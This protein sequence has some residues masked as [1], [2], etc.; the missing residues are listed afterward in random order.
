[1]K[2][3]ILFIAF[4]FCSNQFLVSMAPSSS[5]FS[6]QAAEPSATSNEFLLAQLQTLNKPELNMSCCCCFLSKN[7][8]VRAV[9]KK[10]E[11]AVV[12]SSLDY[13]Q[14]QQLKKFIQEHQ[15]CSGQCCGCNKR[16]WRESAL[17]C[18][19]ILTML[20]GALS[21][22]NLLTPYNSCDNY[23]DEQKELC[24]QDNAEQRCFQNLSFAGAATGICLTCAGVCARRE[25]NPTL[26]KVL[27]LSEGPV[28]TSVSLRVISSVVYPVGGRHP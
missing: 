24:E 12:M 15:G 16:G 2:Q 8:P 4:L 28:Q 1:M 25:C 21:G 9:A 7:E 13:F 14:H 11:D 10:L 20:G 6:V 18:G 3:K 27:A 26:K 23:G 19:I 22:M 5:E 17:A